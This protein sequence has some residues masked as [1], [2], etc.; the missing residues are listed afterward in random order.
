MISFQ[1]QFA[2]IEAVITGIVD[3]YP[4]LKKG[5]RKQI[6]VM[7]LCASMFLLGLPC[8][9]QV[10]KY[11]FPIERNLYYF[12]KLLKTCFTLAYNFFPG[13]FF[14]CP[15]VV[16]EYC[17]RITAIMLSQAKPHL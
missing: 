7:L 13:I 11:N 4:W 9:T 10:L 6:F 15:S 17:L 5:Y 3:E 1:F 12:K 14:L 8:V 2:T 16:L